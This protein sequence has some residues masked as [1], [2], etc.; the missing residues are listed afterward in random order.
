MRAHVEVIEREAL[1]EKQDDLPQVLG[2]VV[3]ADRQL[4]LASRDLSWAPLRAS[5]SAPSMSSFRY[6]G[7]A[8]A[9]ASSIRLH[10]TVTDPVSL[11]A[12]PMPPEALNLTVSFS[13]PT[14]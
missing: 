14:A 9:N 2:L 13:A 12:A 4:G 6:V 10:G 11:I 1:P 8:L 7:L 5:S 3:D